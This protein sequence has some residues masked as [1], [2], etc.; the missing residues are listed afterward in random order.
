MSS[1]DE[2]SVASLNPKKTNL[3]IKKE[4]APGQTVILNENLKVESIKDMT[5]ENVQ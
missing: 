5:I 1:L 2:D 3:E 4:I